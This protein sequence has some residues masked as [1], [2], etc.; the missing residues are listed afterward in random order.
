MPMRSSTTV[1]ATMFVTALLF[2]C[3]HPAK[4]TGGGTMPSTSGGSKDKANLGFN[5][6][7]CAPGELDISGH[8]NFH[9]NKAPAGNMGVL[10]NA[11]KTGEG[12]GI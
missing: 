11:L 4:F 6:K 9:D 7:N 5:M 10:V 3:A 8:F 2:G 12:V 1:A